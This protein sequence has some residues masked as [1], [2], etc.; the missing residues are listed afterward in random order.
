LTPDDT[1]QILLQ[2]FHRIDDL[3]FL[4]TDLRES[5]KKK[6]QNIIY[7]Y[8]EIS[9]H[10][11]D[12]LD[13]F[14]LYE[15]FGRWGALDV[16][17]RWFQRYISPFG[18]PALVKLAFKLPPPI[19]SS[20]QLHKAIIARFL[21]GLY[22]LPINGKDLL[23]FL[24]PSIVKISGKFICHSINSAYRKFL[25]SPSYSRKNRKYLSHDNIRSHYFADTVGK[26]L[27]DMFLK[28]DSFSNILFGKSHTE[29]MINNHISKKN[30][31]MQLIGPLITMEQWSDLV[32]QSYQL[33]RK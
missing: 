30:D 16:C 5:V 33:A 2:K 28:T 21:P 24:D 23:T 15:R 17:G 31:H 4:S 26:N 29:R 6:L 13:L 32:H 1:I 8:N 11:S 12:L 19:G 9:T 18:N 7:C 14:Y 22:Y 3:P 20:Y 27:Y 10:G 25:E